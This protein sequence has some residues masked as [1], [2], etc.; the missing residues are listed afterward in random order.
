MVWVYYPFPV[1]ILMVIKLLLKT[2]GLQMTER[3]GKIM[4]TAS[5]SLIGQAT[6]LKQLKPVMQF[7]TM[8]KAL[9]VGLALREV[10]DAK[11]NS[12]QS[13]I[14]LTQTQKY[15]QLII[16]KILAYTL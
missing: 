6:L 10:R 14:E 3:F 11:A 2:I 12:L 5:L 4:A 8:S 13:I 7:N 16:T 1:V 9:S 15:K